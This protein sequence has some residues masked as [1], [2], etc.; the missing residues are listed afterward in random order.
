MQGVGNRAMA[1]ETAA[2]KAKGGGAPGGRPPAQG[3]AVPQHRFETGDGR[4]DFMIERDG[5]AYAGTHLIIDLY[6]AS[7]IDDIAHVEATLTECVEAAGA[8]MLHIH[9]HHFTPNNGVSG[10]AVLAESHISIHSWPETGYAALDVF[11]CGQADPHRTIAVLRR[12]FNPDRIEVSE[13]LRG[14]GQ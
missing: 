10:V 11:M 2:V 9:L 12:A 7:G 6:G 3:L 1:T 13:H 4:K 8:T 14:G 5:V